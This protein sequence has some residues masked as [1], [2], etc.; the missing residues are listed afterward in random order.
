MVYIFMS[1]SLMLHQVNTSLNT[2]K[3]TPG[4]KSDW[5]NSLWSQIIYVTVILTKP[6]GKAIYR[7]IKNANMSSSCT[8]THL[9]PLGL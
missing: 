2:C 9:E 8:A 7:C 3:E 1:H 5:S 4:M 6:Q